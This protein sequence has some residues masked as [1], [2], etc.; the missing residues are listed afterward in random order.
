MSHHLGGIYCCHYRALFDL[1]TIGKVI[2]HSTSQMY[3][4]INLGKGCSIQRMK[5][6][7]MFKSSAEQVL[8][9]HPPRP[10]PHHLPPSRRFLEPPKNGSDLQIWITSSR[11]EA[12]EHIC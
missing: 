8:S 1:A 12:T 5:K 9:Y 11:E 3:L 7:A 6:N 10:L 2:L 4:N